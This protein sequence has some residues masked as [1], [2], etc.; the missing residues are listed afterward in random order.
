MRWNISK[1]LLAS[2]GGSMAGVKACTKGCMS[3]LDR[4]YFSCQVAGSTMSESSVVDVIRSQPTAAGRASSGIS[5]RQTT[6]RGR[7]WV[8]LVGH[9]VGVGAEQ[10]LEEV[11]VAFGR[12]A[13][14]VRAPQRQRPGP[15]L[16]RID[17]LDR[18][19]D[20]AGGERVRNVGG[21]IGASPAA[22]AA[23]PGRR[24]PMG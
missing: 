2:H 6:S 20:R 18:H 10:V 8:L 4:S 17:I 11:L 3:V 16:G 14:Q 19:L 9:D 13:E 1:S 24:D 22:T 5:S 7:A 21:R 23:A 15:V 12:G